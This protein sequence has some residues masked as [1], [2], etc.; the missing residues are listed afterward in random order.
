MVNRLVT[1]AL[2][3]TYNF[4]KGGELK[5]IYRQVKDHNTEAGAF[6]YKKVENYL[7]TWKLGDDIRQLP[8][9]TKDDVRNYTASLD[10]SLIAS[11]AY[12][13]GS[14]GDPLKIP[15][16][17]KRELIRT[18]SIAYYNEMGGYQIGDRFLFIRAK[19]KSKLKQILRNELLFIPSDISPEKIR[20]I[21]KKIVSQNVTVLIGYPT[22]IYEI[23]LQ[24]EKDKDFKKNHSVKSVITVS[25][26]L[27]H[28]KRQLIKNIFDCTLLDR[29][30]N[31]ETGVIAQQR[32]FGGDYLVDR[33]G[34]YVE[35]LV[36]GTMKPARENERGKVVLTDVYNDLVPIVRYDTGDYAIVSKYKDG[37]LYSIKCVVGRTSEEIF[38]TDG[39]PVSSLILGPYI[40]QPFSE[41]NIKCQFQ[42]S[43]VGK[44][45]Y[46][47]RIK[48]VEDEQFS[49]PVRKV[50]EG[51][52]KILG[53]DAHVEIVFL[54]DIAPLPSG[55][56]PLYRNEMNN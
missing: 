36:P 51:V 33:F 49:K 32:E 37:H 53:K 34:V 27:D 18:A 38:A 30:S 24:L 35:V 1:R 22:V 52:K 46:Q 20:E 10:R 41:A 31:E 48:G 43:Q 23:A 6:D 15:L 12:T 42:F 5:K 2:F 3:S 55:K 14:S 7:K 29:Y 4:V 28:W 45:E 56:R 40:H 13:G 8:I 16:S 19:Q 26:P 25:E 47:L 54:S 44:K 39:I 21:T 50:V 17:R 9:M 11:Y